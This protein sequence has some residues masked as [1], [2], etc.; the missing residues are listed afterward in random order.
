MGKRGKRH[1]EK[2]KNDRHKSSLISKYI[3]GKWTKYH[4]WRQRSAEQIKS[5][6][7]LF[8]R[9][10]SDSDTKTTRVEED[11]PHSFHKAY[12]HHTKETLRQKLLLDTEKTPLQK[13]PSIRKNNSIWR[14]TGL[15][16]SGEREDI[17]DTVNHVD[18]TRIYRTLNN[19]TVSQV[20]MEHSPGYR[21]KIHFKALKSYTIYSLATW[22]KIRNQITKE[23]LG[24]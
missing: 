16:V 11:V 21:Y 18:L 24:N 15:K 14:T 10:T 8:S 3:K 2:L 12:G 1:V 4:T 6:N 23:N 22:N 5:H 13:G 7:Q 17:N 9:S 20:Y 19:R